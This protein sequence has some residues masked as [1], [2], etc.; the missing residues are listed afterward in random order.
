LQL[1]AVGLCTLIVFKVEDEF[2]KV[3]KIYYNSKKSLI[4]IVNKELQTDPVM[5]FDIIDLVKGI[6]KTEGFGGWDF[7]ILGEGYRLHTE[8]EGWIAYN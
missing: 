3:F 5:A 4:A 2:N 6:I 1:T 8:G 7:S